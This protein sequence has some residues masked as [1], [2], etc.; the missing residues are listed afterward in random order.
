MCENQYANTDSEN[1][2]KSFFESLKNVDIIDIS[3]YWEKNNGQYDKTMSQI[4]KQLNNKYLTLIKD[5]YVNFIRGFNLL[6]NKPGD[7]NNPKLFGN[8]SI[9]LRKKNKEYKGH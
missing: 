1:I 9:I 2:I 5:S 6:E 8:I 7:F 3:I 4:K